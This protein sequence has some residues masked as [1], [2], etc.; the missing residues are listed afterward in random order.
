MAL[1][2]QL[3]DTAAN[4][5]AAAIGTL[6]NGGS[7]NIYSGSQPANANAGAGGATLLATLTLPSPTFGSA[8]GGVL[9]ANAITAQNAVA[10]GL[11]T[12]FRVLKSDAS[13]VVYDGTVGT[14]GA[15]MNMSNTSL[16]AGGSVAITSLQFSLVE[17]GS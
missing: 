10:T 5:G 9:T 8:S 17:A 13:T 16:V 7:I 12:W 2:T 11:A 4:A 1:N 14:S 3:S 6:C 15:N